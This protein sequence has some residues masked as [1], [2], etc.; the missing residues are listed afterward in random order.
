MSLEILSELLAVPASE[1]PGLLNRL[2]GA[3]AALRREVE[4]LLAR[5]SEAADFL[6]HPPAA[7]LAEAFAPPDPPIEPG[8]LV[9]DRY[10][11]LGLLGHGGMGKVYRAEDRRLGQRVALKLLPE[12]LAAN[13]RSLERFLEEVRIARQVSHPNIC[14]VFDLG[15]AGGLRFLSM[16]LIDGQDLAELLAERQPPRPE[17]ALEIALELCAGLAAIHERGIVH[18]DLKPANVMLDA[19]GRVRVMDFG[20]AALAATLDPAE[21]RSGTPAYMA[22]E[23]A[24]GSEHTVRSDLYALGLVLYELFTGRRALEAD[25]AEELA[26]QHREE[27]PAPLSRWVEGV[28]AAIERAVLSCLA[29]RPAER[30]ASAEAVALLLRGN[31]LPEAGT[32]L[33][34]VVASGS[35]R[36]QAVIAELAERWGGL[37]LV[38]PEGRCW[39]FERPVGAVR[40][41]VEVQQAAVGGGWAAGV[42]VHLGEVEILGPGGTAGG[43]PALEARGEA[44]DLAARLA[45]LARPGQTLTTG[46]AF[47]LARRSARREERADSLRWLAHG[48]YLFRGR[49]RPVEVFEVGVEGAAPFAAP[50]DSRD[51]SSLVATDTIRGWRPAP[52]LAVPHRPGWRLIRQLGASG[53][54]EVWLAERSPGGER[55]VFKF[56]F[57]ESRLRGLRREIT[58]FRLLKE[59]LGER[60]DI[61]PILGWN[62]DEAPYFLESEYTAGGSLAEWAERQGG[63]DR[64]PLELRLD[65]VAQVAD[66]LAAAHSVGV[67][68][69]DVKPGNIL[70]HEEGDGSVQ[71]RLADFGIG[72]LTDRSRLAGAEFTVMGMTDETGDGGGSSGSGTRLYM[73]PE[74]LE[75]EPASLQTDVYA[76]GVTLF[77]VVV[78]NLGRALAPGWRREIDSELLAED[79]AWAV[80]GRPERR[81][82]DPSRLAWRLRNLPERRVARGAERS[83][84]SRQRRMARRRRVAEIAAAILLVLG[85]GLAVMVARVRQEAERA[86][87]EAEASER[88]SRFF[89]ELFETADP[90][91]VVETGEP[92]GASMTARQLLDRGA[93]KLETEL[94]DQPEIR[95]RLMTTLSRVYGYL[96]LQDAADEQTRRAL[97]LRLQLY[98]EDHPAV[99]ESLYELAWAE[100]EDTEAERIFRRALEIRRH[101]LG[102]GHPD[103][104]ESLNGLARNLHFQGEYEQAEPLFREALEVQ[105]DTLGD[106]AQV[107]ETLHFL[108][109]VLLEVN[110][111]DAAEESFR[112][113]LAISERQGH[114]AHV[115]IGIAFLGDVSAERGDW[116]EAVRLYRE[117]QAMRDRG[118]FGEDHHEVL[119]DDG[120]LALALV[121]VGKAREAEPVIRRVVDVGERTRADEVSRAYWDGVMGACLDGLG[122]HQE[123]EPL[124]LRAHRVLRQTSSD[125]STMTRSVVRSLEIHYEALGEPERAG[126]YRELFAATGGSRG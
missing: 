53:F 13:P 102:D 22:P 7:A 73:A 80:E 23:Q 14:R 50:E 86:N 4:A 43:A 105:R 117:S 10:R 89:I 2:C 72:L 46:H 91:A 51:A 21:L 42:G 110:E 116:V 56:C 30:P 79:I 33:R 29:K 77:Q 94:L 115:V 109:M 59:A 31:R 20:L 66:A 67:L 111:L 18:R 24:S 65:I 1:R 17:R 96:D 107:V 87:R 11:I 99:A 55:R 36:R 121:R 69:K 119:W 92:V 112:E 108:G 75:G 19:E 100:S 90:W 54:G 39:I 64:M 103:Y 28:D 34:T 93:R 70:I 26:R 98:G 3:N 74:L 15:E 84:E 106:G 113:A 6:T 85:L 40:Y 76:L 101:T 125:R 88:V 81:L 97:E 38:S 60:R 8:T 120:K 16:E 41:A 45:S 44:L 47:D 25:S 82:R 126:D 61:A 63:I 5:E 37:E 95:A 57:E 12:A 49:P 48:A 83:A 78:G 27:M 122:R 58:L 124:L 52:G 123:A 71:A 68:H 118:S 104:A 62:L 35:G 114:T 9:G 32:L